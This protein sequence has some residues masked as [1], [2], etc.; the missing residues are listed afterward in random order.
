MV[1]CHC[2]SFSHLA[3]CSCWPCTTTSTISFSTVVVT[4]PCLRSAA[5]S[6]ARAATSGS[7][8]C[9]RASIS[10]WKRSLSL[11]AR[12][13]TAAPVLHSLEY[14]FSISSQW[15]VAIRL[16]VPSRRSLH[17]ELLSARMLLVTLSSS[18]AFRVQQ[19]A[20]RQFPCP[21]PLCSGCCKGGGIE[22]FLSE[23]TYITVR[24]A[25]KY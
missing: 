8:R 10:F 25:C 4:D 17:L 2:G 20:R 7:L 12:P 21:L 14:A 22:E 6:I 1:V 23:I 9:R 18:A 24:R 5:T 11:K 13:M 19:A 3:A 16:L 15:R